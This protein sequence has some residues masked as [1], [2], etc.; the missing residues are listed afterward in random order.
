MEEQKGR[1][2]EKEAGLENDK[3][4]REIRDKG[5]IKT[6]FLSSNRGN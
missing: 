3:N 4:R 5:T 2:K 6:R 1:E